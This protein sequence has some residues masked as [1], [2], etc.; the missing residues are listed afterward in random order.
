[1][2]YDRNEMIFVHKQ[3]AGSVII[4]A[5]INNFMEISIIWS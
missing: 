5:G 4:Y 1:M 3:R 2:S